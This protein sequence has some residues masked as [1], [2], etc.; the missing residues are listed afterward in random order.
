[1]SKPALPYLVNYSLLC[2]LLYTGVL[3]TNLV[4][5]ERE[6]EAVRCPFWGY[7]MYQICLGHT[8]LKT[9]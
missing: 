5:N 9:N 1:M 7:K 3:H 6:G 2:S 8:S 4:Q